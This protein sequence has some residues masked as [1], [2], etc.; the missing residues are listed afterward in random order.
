MAPL[1]QALLAQVNN[2]HCP[3]NVHDA[4]RVARIGSREAARTLI[5][6]SLNELIE[7]V[8]AL[9]P[10]VLHLYAADP[11]SV[12][13][14]AGKE[15]TTSLGELS[16]WDEPKGKWERKLAD[17][18]ANSHVACA[19]LDAAFGENLAHALREA[20]VPA[21]VHWRQSPPRLAAEQY[22]AAF[23][24]AFVGCNSSLSFAHKFALAAFSAMCSLPGGDGFYCPCPMLL[25]RISL[26]FTFSLCVCVFV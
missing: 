15:T 24:T 11:G 16:F 26:S 2:A 14:V 12:M 10:P 7:A 18:C 19:I 1:V 9:Q 13:P 23:F 25:V 20:G 8:H 17:A 6:P 22:S 4:V 21:V 5:T 3:H